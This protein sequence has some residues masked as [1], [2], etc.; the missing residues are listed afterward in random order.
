MRALRV[1]E[2][3]VLR[4]AVGPKSDETTRGWLKSHDFYSLP[5]APHGSVQVAR[6]LAEN[7]N[8]K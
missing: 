4:K 6:K 1:F 5:A 7:E 8:F 2:N 3:I